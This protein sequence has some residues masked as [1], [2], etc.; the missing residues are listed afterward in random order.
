MSTIMQRYARR[1]AAAV[2][3]AAVSGCAQA[4]SLGNVLGSVLGGG[5]A[6]GSQVSGTIQ[7][8]DTRNQQINLRQSNGQGVS[9]VFD[10][11]TKVVYQ[12]Q[13]YG[14]TSLEYGDQ[15]TARVQSTQNGAYYTDLVQ[16]D[17]PVA[18]SGGTTS[19]A[20][21][22]TLQGSVR[23]VDVQNG[24]FEI[25]S[26]NQVLTVSMP[27]N[28]TRSDQQRFQNLRV[29]DVTR[30]AGVYLNNSRVE[31]RQFQ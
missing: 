20:Q 18:G 29:G 1:T 14:I 4:G 23:R 24:L 12:N 7:N 16:V 5:Q 30:F 11:Q 13:S 19:N 21:V 28:P 31:L 27:Y 10:Q 17:Q 15:V 8:V 6:G 26:N 2:A 25:T 3:I 22:Y 9:L